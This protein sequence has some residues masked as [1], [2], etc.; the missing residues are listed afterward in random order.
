MERLLD[1]MLEESRTYL[2]FERIAMRDDSN[3]SGFDG[4]GF[5]SFTWAYR[6]EKRTPYGSEIKSSVARLWYREPV[7]EDEAHSIEATSVAQIFQI[8]KQS[9]VSEKKERVYPIEKFLNMKMHQIV[10]ECF[11]E[12]ERVLAKY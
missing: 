5:P 6:F 3:R 10:M 12:A 1:A 2:E 7:Y 11:A 4:G 8:G 9:R